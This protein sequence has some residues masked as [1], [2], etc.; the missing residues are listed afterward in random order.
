MKQ[1]STVILGG[2]IAGLCA[3][4]R[5]LELGE[6]PVVIEAGH[7]P[8]HKVCGEFLSSTSLPILGKWGIRPVPIREVC[9]HA[10]RN[11]FSMS[12][13]E[14]AGSLSHMTLDV[15]LA[16]QI[17]EQGAIL[18]TGTK[19]TEIIPAASQNKM[20]TLQL[21]DG[22][23]IST[24]T[25]MIASGRYP[26]PSSK[27]MIPAYIGFKTHF[28]GIKLDSTLH[29]FSFKG[30]YLGLSPVEDGKVNLACL[31]TMEEVRK[32]PTPL[33]FLERILAC[34]PYLSEILASGQNLLDNWME[35]SIP[36][37]GF[38]STPDWTRSY[39]IGDAAC[40]V[41]PACGNGLSMAI[42][43][44]C[45]AAE[46]AVKGDADGFKKRWRNICR[47]QLYMGRAMH[48]LFLNP[49]AGAAAIHLCR[50][51]PSLPRFVAA[52]RGWGLQGL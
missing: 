38:R 32:F 25:I 1:Y 39:W 23:T 18:L 27:S 11:A 37:F 52:N 12:F 35:A 50:Y 28:S 15:Q 17:V 46:Y 33:L 47:G 26:H 42:A 7:Y 4:K 8:S 3:A 41:P 13:P 51:F 6:N 5:L 14:Q 24:R 9:V 45:L 43:C 2:G 48:R 36:E 19:V 31:G 49:S 34:H 30:A 21:A 40:T 29:M 20:H 10:S 22:S 16:K 44:G